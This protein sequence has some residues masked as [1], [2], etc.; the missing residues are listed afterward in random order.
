VIEALPFGMVQLGQLE[1]FRA[2][3]ERVG[4]LALP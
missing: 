4:A 2:L 3:A 1:R